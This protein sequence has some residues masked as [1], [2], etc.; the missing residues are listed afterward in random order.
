MNIMQNSLIP[1]K[2]A[3]FKAMRFDRPTNKA[4]TGYIRAAFSIVNSASNYRK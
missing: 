3:I 2:T 1:V 4:A